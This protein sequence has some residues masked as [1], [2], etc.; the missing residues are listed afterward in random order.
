[1]CPRGRGG[2]VWGA[3][4]S[5]AGRRRPPRRGLSGVGAAPV[6]ER[7]ALPARQRGPAARTLRN[8]R[9]HG[10]AR[11]RHRARPGGD[12]AAAVRAAPGAA[13][14]RARRR[15]DRRPVAPL[16]AGRHTLRDRAGAI[17]RH[18]GLDRRC[19]REGKPDRAQGSPAH[20]RGRLRDLRAGRGVLLEVWPRRGG[21]GHLATVEL[22]RRRRR[23]SRDFARRGLLPR[24]VARRPRRLHHHSVGRDRP[25]IQVRFRETRQRARH[26]PLRLR[27]RHALRPA[28]V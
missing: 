15:H 18:R 24:A 6:R 5:A 8:R 28:R 4:R 19:D 1:M 11:G 12:V 13:G 26:R 16:G 22:C 7:A 25:G 21:A 2:G 9:R 23:D 10:G 27:Q 20:E 14:Q 17:E 3:E